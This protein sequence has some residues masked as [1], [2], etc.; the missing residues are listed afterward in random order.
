M[1]TGILNS[2]FRDSQLMH[3][4]L[5]PIAIARVPMAERNKQ[6]WVVFNGDCTC[7]HKLTLNY[8]PCTYRSCR[9]SPTTTYMYMHSL[10]PPSLFL[11][12][13]VHMTVFPLQ[14]HNDCQHLSPV[15]W[16]QCNKCDNHVSLLNKE[17]V[18][19][20]SN[21]TMIAIFISI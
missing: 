21:T 17:G 20:P 9:S 14:F 11:L 16:H 18:F 1:C 10:P 19:A 5:G 13:I 7:M 6:S 8:V 4:V 12:K 3:L 15:P 2:P